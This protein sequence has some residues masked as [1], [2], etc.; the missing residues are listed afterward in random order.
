MKV[1]IIIIIIINFIVT[2][3]IISLWRTEHIRCLIPD[4]KS[5]KY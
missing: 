3:F 1:I 5:L 2:T 4:R